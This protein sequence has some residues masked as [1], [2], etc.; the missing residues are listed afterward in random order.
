[1]G[2][3][4]AAQATTAAPKYAH[5]WLNPKLD[6]GQRASELLAQ[7]TLAQKLQMVDGTGFAFGGGVDYAGHIQ[8]IPALGIP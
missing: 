1:M 2:A 3:G 6:P 4:S 5:A 7:M 8:G